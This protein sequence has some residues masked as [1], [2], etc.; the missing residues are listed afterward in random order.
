MKEV[1]IINDYTSG[2]LVIVNPEMRISVKDFWGETNICEGTGVIVGVRNYPLEYWQFV[3][4]NWTAGVWALKFM[5]RRW[6]TIG[7][8]ILFLGEGARRDF[9]G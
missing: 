4:Q 2:R 8:I 7:A 9:D 5:P 1:I 6:F 3:G